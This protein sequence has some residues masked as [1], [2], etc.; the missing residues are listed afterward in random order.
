MKVNSV[1]GKV[2]VCPKS[3]N[4][5][6]VAEKI[7]RKYESYRKLKMGKNFYSRTVIGNGIVE[8]LLSRVQSFY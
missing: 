1:S 4:F 2:V 5:V 6:E 8:L 3:P 7:Y